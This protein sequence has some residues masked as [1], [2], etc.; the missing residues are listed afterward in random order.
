MDKQ[1]FVIQGAHGGL[2]KSYIRFFILRPY[3][4]LFLGYF[5]P[6]GLVK[7]YFFILFKEESFRI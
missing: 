2:T 4:V 5:L 3:K 7:S 1:C 6:G